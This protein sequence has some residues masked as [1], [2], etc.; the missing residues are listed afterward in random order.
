MYAFAIND[1]GAG[2]LSS[3][4]FQN[5]WTRHWPIAAHLS[6]RR[7]DSRDRLRQAVKND[8]MQVCMNEKSKFYGRRDVVSRAHL[9]LNFLYDTVHIFR[10]ILHTPMQFV[11]SSPCKNHSSVF[12]CVWST[13]DITHTLAVLKIRIAPIWLPLTNGFL[14]EYSLILEVL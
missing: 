9:T 13:G 5:F 14:L 6:V 7:L 11:L 3:A 10:N 1:D 2:A 8:S 12:C 4:P